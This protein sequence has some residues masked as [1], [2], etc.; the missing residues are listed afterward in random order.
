MKAVLMSI[1]P[2]YVFLIIARIMGLDIPLEKT[3][4][5][6]KNIPTSNEWNRHSVIYCSKDK[7]SFHRIPAEYQSFMR[8][9]LGKVIGE[10]IC[11][12]IDEICLECSD[13]SKLRPAEIPYIG[14]TDKEIVEYLGNGKT[15]YGLHISNLKIYD[16]PR[17]LSEFNDYCKYQGMTKECLRED[18]EFCNY[19][20]EYITLIHHIKCEKVLTRPPQSWCYVEELSI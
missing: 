2:Y 15:G 19:S 17:E 8:R 18:G 20:Y 4:E 3:I 7:K 16:K 1:K 5:V 12:R 6:R 11:D 14:L 9:F 10:F 13:W